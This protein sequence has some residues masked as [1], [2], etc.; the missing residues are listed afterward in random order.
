VIRDRFPRSPH[1]NVRILASLDASEHSITTMTWK[2][3]TRLTGKSRPHPL[4]QT[5]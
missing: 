2:L 1:Q 5:H 3:S 4:D